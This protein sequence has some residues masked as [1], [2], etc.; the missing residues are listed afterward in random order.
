VLKRR[1]AGELIG[2]YVPTR[3]NNVV[4]NFYRDLGFEPIDS[5]QGTTRWRLPLNEKLIP[6]PE[7]IAIDVAEETA[8]A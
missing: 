2:E 4:V 5:Q 7:W 1:G 3:K 8:H 6:I